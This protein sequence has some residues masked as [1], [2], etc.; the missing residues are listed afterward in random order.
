MTLAALVL[1]DRFLGKV[2]SFRLKY[3]ALGVLFVDVSI[4]GTLTPF[5]TPPMLSAA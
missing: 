1:A 5:A 3:A 2:I 4:S